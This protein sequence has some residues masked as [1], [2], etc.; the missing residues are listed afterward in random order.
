MKFRQIGLLAAA[1]C[2]AVVSVAAVAGSPE[3]MRDTQ[4][5]KVVKKVSPAVVYISSTHKVKNPFFN[6]FAGFFGMD[7]FGSSGPEQTEH[8]LGSGFIVSPKGYILTNEHVIMGGT[9]IRVT[10]IDGRTFDAKVVGTAPESDLALLKIDGK[11]PFPTLTLGRSDNLMIGEP[12]IAVGNPFGL[13][14]TVTTGVLSAIGRTVKDG[15]RTYS[16]FLQTDAAINPGNSGGPLLDILGKVIGINTAIIKDATGIGFAIP[17]D[18]AKRVMEQLRHYG[19]VRPAWLGFLPLDLSETARLRHHLPGGVVVA[20]TYPF[21]DSEALRLKRG[22]IL[23]TIDGQPLKNAGDINAK[24]AVVNP[25]QAV[26]LGG[27]RD[28]KPINVTLHVKL[29]P[30]RLTPDMAW[31]LLGLRVRPSQGAMEITDV[32]RGSPAEA[33]GLRPGDYLL[34]VEDHPVKTEEEFL[35]RARSALAST[36]LLISV[37]RGPWTYYVTLNLMES[38]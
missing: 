30:K 3:S 35:T 31:V 8:S 32:R 6:P 24:I 7:R 10:L 21:A 16:D 15:K 1:F 37:Q 25:G 38:Q 17:I 9:Q 19:R 33:T 23:T 11:K 27:L 22:D 14:N 26:T 5:V 36:G 20:R 34:A 4:V 18:R 2:L 12:T 13:S 29:M 28:G